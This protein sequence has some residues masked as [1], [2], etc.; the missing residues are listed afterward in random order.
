MKTAGWV[1]SGFLI[2]CAP[3]GALTGD[4]LQPPPRPARE[5]GKIG[6]RTEAVDLT[7]YARVLLVAADGS[8]AGDGSP[9]APLATIPQALSKIADAGEAKRQAILVA[10]GDYRGETIRM[11]PY[12][13]LFGG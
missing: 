6:P 7:A 3:R 12:V 5:P 13:D 11:K 10:A 4:P 2:A 1:V 9:G 8:E